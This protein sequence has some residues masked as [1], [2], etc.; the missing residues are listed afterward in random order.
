M[1]FSDKRLVDTFDDYIANKT[2]KIP[3]PIQKVA[4]K[5]EGITKR[6]LSLEEITNYNSRISIVHE[7]DSKTP[8]NTFI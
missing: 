5:A 1:I 4:E 6:K 2:K 7:C 3:R 8:F